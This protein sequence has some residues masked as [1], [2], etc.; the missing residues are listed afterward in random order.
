M[1]IAKIDLIEDIT[2]VLGVHP[3]CMGSQLKSQRMLE[4]GLGIGGQEV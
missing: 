4:L 2:K 3:N 1:C